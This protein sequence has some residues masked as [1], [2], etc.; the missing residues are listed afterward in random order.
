[1]RGAS[2]FTPEMKNLGL[3]THLSVKTRRQR[4]DLFGLRVKLPPVTTSESNHSKVEAIPLSAL[5]K[6]TKSG[7]AG[8]S[9]L[10]PFFIMNVKQ[11]SCEF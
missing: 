1:M 4:S 2:S 10:Y 3:D 11:G 9:S 7:L 8:L 5:P 6:D